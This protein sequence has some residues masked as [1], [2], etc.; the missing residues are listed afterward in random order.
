MSGSGTHSHN[1][2]G[3]RRR[4]LSSPNSLLLPVDHLT[5]SSP[6]RGK[7]GGDQKQRLVSPTS[8][9]ASARF[10]M[11]NSPTRYRKNRAKPDTKLLDEIADFA[12]TKLSIPDSSFTES[13]TQQKTPAR[14]HRDTRRNDNLNDTH[15]Q[16]QQILSSSPSSITPLH[17]TTPRTQPRTDSNTTGTAQSLGLGLINTS[18]SPLTS[19][20]TTDTTSLRYRIQGTLTILDINNVASVRENLL[21]TFT[22]ES[23]ASRPRKLQALFTY[24]GETVPGASLEL[25]KCCCE[26]L[27]NRKFSMMAIF[28]RANGVEIGSLVDESKVRTRTLVW[29]CKSSSG[30]GGSG[31]SGS[32]SGDTKLDKIAQLL[33]DLKKSLNSGLETGS[34]GQ[35]KLERAKDDPSL[36]GKV[37]DFNKNW[38][39]E[40]RHE[41]QVISHTALIRKSKFYDKSNFTSLS[42]KRTGPSASMMSSSRR[43]C[44]SPTLSLGT[45][46][47]E[48]PP[49][50]STKSVYRIGIPNESSMSD[51]ADDEETERR[52]QRNQ[53]PGQTQNRNNQ[54]NSGSTGS[55]ARKTG[56]SRITTAS[57]YSSLRNQ[58]LKKTARLQD[59]DTNDTRK[60]HRMEPLSCLLGDDDSNESKERDIV[61]EFKPSLNY[62]FNDGTSYTITNQDF[63]CLYNNDWINDTIIDFFIKYFVAQSIDN[64]IVKEQEVCIMSSFFYTKLV[65]KPEDY[66][67]N[68]KKWVQN[69]N[70]L[71]KRYIVIPVNTSFHWF[72]CI[73]ANLNV[74]AEYLIERGTK[75]KEAN[76]QT[77]GTRTTV[78]QD[79][80]SSRTSFH[81]ASDD[82]IPGVPIVE[83]LTFDSLRGQHTRDIDPIKDFLVVYAQDNYGLV[84]DKS[85]IKMKNCLVPQQPNMSDCG[86]HVILTVKKFF[87][88]PEKTMS[89]WRSIKRKCRESSLLVNE[90]FEKNKRNSKARKDLRS[91]LWELH[92]EQERDSQSKCGGNGGGQPGVKREEEDDGDLEIIEGVPD[93]SRT[94]DPISQERT[95]AANSSVVDVP[96]PRGSSVKFESVSSPGKH[97]YLDSHDNDDNDDEGDSRDT[98]NVST[99]LNSDFRPAYSQELQQLSSPP[100]SNRPSPTKEDSDDHG[101]EIPRDQPRRRLNSSVTSKFFKHSHLRYEEVATPNGNSE[102][103]S[104]NNYRD[105]KS[106]GTDVVQS[107]GN[108][109]SSPVVSPQYYGHHLYEHRPS[110]PADS[111]DRKYSSSSTADEVT[112]YEL[113]GNNFV[114]SA[115]Q[116]EHYQRSEALEKVNQVR[117]SISKEL[118]EDVPIEYFGYTKTE[119]NWSPATQDESDYVVGGDLDQNDD[120]EDMD[121]RDD[122]IPSNQLI[123]TISLDDDGDD[124]T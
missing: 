4:L 123:P 96:G 61:R 83:I 35:L 92:C 86:V 38:L 47:S 63:K 32:S 55:H 109:Q 5:G 118:Q 69:S 97:N 14:D 76:H 103:L 113:E 119:K 46:S 91:I 85:W 37:F 74:L 87:E 17:T 53:N 43:T 100:Y 56:Q 45:G 54:D 21:L 28:L 20:N 27:F 122:D 62:R 78:G 49:V 65:S 60:S 36:W 26:I 95:S 111:T 8:T 73:I 39:T 108:L 105:Q 98:S 15:Q 88:D 42:R 80:E 7:A 93:S 2:S 12:S 120:V 82:V 51:D 79:L 77:D 64:G 31:N 75:T 114:S 106:E 84:I 9:R 48:S 115:D 34:Y 3:K 107:N 117:K 16:P 116:N 18:L 71:Q 94:G 81:V 68:V 59:T 70:L 10:H 101:I 6:E 44:A 121:V 89:V 1:S 29:Q 13:H 58:P 23:H 11:S 110:A 66:Y 52:H 124:N 50:V 30:G 19:R 22:Y 41:K 90:Y 25:S 112:I 104:D 40:Q 33:L 24:R 72:G 102:P 99:P 57:F 67:G